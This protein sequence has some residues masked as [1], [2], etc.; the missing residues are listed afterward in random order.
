MKMKTIV[1]G[2]ALLA[3]VGV[4]VLGAQ[5]IYAQ[6]PSQSAR[7]ALYVS[8]F[9]L[10]DPEGIKPYS[11]QVDGTFAPFSGRYVVRGGRTV[12][13]EGEPP[14]RIVV[15]AFDRWNKHRL[16]ITRLLIRRSDPSV[17]NRRS[18]E[19]TWSRALPIEVQ[20]AKASRPRCCSIKR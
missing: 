3:I 17:I 19:F 11:Q 14:K 15:I 10:T 18:R 1:Q 4:G 7:P 2:S 8:E 13:L 20:H 9:E 16:G 5:S 6:A 12:S